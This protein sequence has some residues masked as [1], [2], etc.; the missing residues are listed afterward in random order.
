MDGW[1]DGGYLVKALCQLVLN[2]ELPF[3]GAQ[4]LRELRSCH[5]RRERVR[6]ERAVD[7]QVRSMEVDE[8][9]IDR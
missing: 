9:K 7:I 1:M 3:P 5:F 2:L 6:R 4:Q 8:M